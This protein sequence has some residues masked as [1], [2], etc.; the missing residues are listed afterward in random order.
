MSS[1]PSHINE[2]LARARSQRF[3]VALASDLRDIQACQALRYRV[4]AEEMGAELHANDGLD[5]D[6]FDDFCSHLMVTDRRTGEL[7]ATTRLLTCRDAARA[8]RFY[9]QSEFEL[10]AILGLDGTFLEVGR[11]C[12]ALAYRNSLALNMLWQG[13]ARMMVLYKVD[14][15]FGC[16]S[17]PMGDNGAYAASV[18][19]YLRHH[20]M[21]DEDLRVTPHMPLPEW[22]GDTTV[23]AVLP[24][25][26]KRYLKLGAVVCGEPCWD[27]DFDVADVFILVARDRINQRY[28]KRFIDNV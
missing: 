22:D 18:M 5:I 16:A 1:I 3:D 10:R 25:L 17:V 23:D 27:R 11:T 4:F 28:Q 14:Y 21:A 26:L 15:L 13:I 24:P 19:N 9:A 7:V 8:G 2:Q 6:Y 12:V 20:H